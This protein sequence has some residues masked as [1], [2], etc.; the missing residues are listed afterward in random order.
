MATK[1]LDFSLRLRHDGH[2]LS[3]VSQQLGFDSQVGWDKG[4]QNRTLRG[5]LRDGT[6][7]SS[8]RS[9]AMGVV[10]GTDLDDALPACL[11]KLAPFAAVL[12]SFVTSGGMASLAIGWFS[13]SDVGGGRISAETIA[14]MAR[15]SLTLDLYL[16]LQ[17]PSAT[18]S[19]D[20]ASAGD[21]AT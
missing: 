21:P 4:D 8:Y 1:K 11:A 15:L 13:D 19:T 18:S 17:P 2:D 9:F 5:L 3:V 16:Y 14:E 20:H 10:M 12:Q 7:D 6:R